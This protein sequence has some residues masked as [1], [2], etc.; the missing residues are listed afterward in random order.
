MTAFEV[1]VS[2][3]WLFLHYFRHPVRLIVD[4]IFTVKVNSVE[5]SLQC[6][7]IF[8]FGLYSLWAIGYTQLLS[9]YGKRKK[10]RK[11][12]ILISLA[13]ITHGQKIYF[14]SGYCLPGKERS[15]EKRG[16]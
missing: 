4:D 16:F 6:K 3:D 7:R 8:V 2:N 12:R 11:T 14:G 10:Q 13:L 15:K 1:S 5:F 9:F